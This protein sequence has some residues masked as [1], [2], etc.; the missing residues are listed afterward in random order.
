MHETMFDQFAPA[1]KRLGSRGRHSP[2]FSLG[3]DG[4]YEL[5]YIPFEHLNRDARL[6]IVGITPGPNQIELAYDTAQS[7]LM[8]GMRTEQILAEV[9]KAG[10][11][12]GQAMRPNLLRMLRHFP[13][14]R[15]LGIEDVATLWSADARLLHSTSVVPHAVFESGK[16][17]NGKFDAILKSPLLKQCFLDSFV[18]SI[19]QLRSDAIYVALGDT[20]K[21]ALE[22][23]VSQGYL[24]AQQVLGA[25]CHPSSSGGSATAYY[26]REKTLA[27][28]NEKDPVRHRTA[29]LDEYYCQMHASIS[30]LLGSAGRVAE[31]IP[32]PIPP[33]TAAPRMSAPDAEVA[34]KTK[35]RRM[36]TPAGA[37]PDDEAEA[38]AEEM[39]FILDQIVVAG[40]T[41]THEIKK[42]AEVQ[43]RSGQVVY[44]VKTHSKMN[45][46]VLAVHPEHAP[47]HLSRLPG[48]ESVSSDY[49][50]HSNMSRF[51]KK[52][53]KGEKETQYGWHVITES[54]GDCQRFLASF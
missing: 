17:F 25:F 19:A 32:A 9:K 34:E 51:P 50:F 23:C 31:P 13:F 49:R 29:V 20:P 46:I 22:W 10:S 48:V 45:R 12:G 52:K 2:E 7:L 42:V 38:R 4:L 37:E 1:L 26:L 11:F 14:N 18:A 28:L 24:R 6:V 47:E 43:T 40:N 30:A 39:R 54:V 21:G 8:S 27:D 44:L 3:K 35:E 33:P 41:L 16:P 53:N 36:S 15:L 5:R